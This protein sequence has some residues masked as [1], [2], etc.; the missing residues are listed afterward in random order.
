MPELVLA[1]GS[2]RRRE[3]LAF[4]GVDFIVHPAEIDEEKVDA[5]TPAE[6]AERLA[7]LKSRQVADRL[8]RG[9]VLAADT[10]VVLESGEILG[11]PAGPEEAAAMLRR[12]SGN[13]HEVITGVAI[14]DGVSD[15]QQIFHEVTKVMF[16]ELSEAEIQRYVAT[17]EPLDKAGA[18][19]IQ[20][21]GALLVRRVEG[22][23]FNVVG[24]PLA[25]VGEALKAFDIELL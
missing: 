25:R 16:R 12:L 14:I 21:R 15:R 3:L 2:P 1:S 6:L 5:A 4:L 9:I 7:W 19:G 18:Y 22:C 17:G 10:V 13:T 20:R 8:R 23:Y 11:K 24:L